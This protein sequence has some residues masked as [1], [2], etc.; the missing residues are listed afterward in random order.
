MKRTQKTIA[1]VIVFA[2]AAVGIFVIA[3]H[4]TNTKAIASGIV[5]V[6]AA[7]AVGFAW[8]RNA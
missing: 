1:M 4:G 7:V 3:V 6:I 2:A 5:L 8:S